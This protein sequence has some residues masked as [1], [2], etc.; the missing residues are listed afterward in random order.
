MLEQADGRVRGRLELT[1]NK[2]EVGNLSCHLY[3]TE[4]DGRWYGGERVCWREQLRNDDVEHDR[5]KFL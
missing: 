5:V 3:H 2:L 4:R 1:E